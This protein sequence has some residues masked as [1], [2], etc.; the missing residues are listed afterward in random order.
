MYNVIL[1]KKDGTQYYVGSNG[2][3]VT[4]YNDNDS[5]HYEFDS[6]TDAENVKM[7]YL[8]DNWNIDNEFGYE[9]EVVQM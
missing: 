1:T 2:K 5:I 9:I 4:E 3:L 7:D 6:W 8:L